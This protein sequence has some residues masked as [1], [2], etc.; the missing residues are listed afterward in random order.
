MSCC[1]GRNL[2]NPNISR[3]SILGSFMGRPVEFFALGLG[4]PQ[5]WLA[6]K[7][8]CRICNIVIKNVINEDIYLM[9][10]YYF[11]Y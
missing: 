7:L 6:G 4:V 8:F 5:S 9:E 10:K 11:K 1:P 2:S 3:R